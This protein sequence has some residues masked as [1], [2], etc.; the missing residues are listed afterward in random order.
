MSDSRGRISDALWRLFLN[1]MGGLGLLLAVIWLLH[2]S[3]ALLTPY[4]SWIAGA[5]ALGVFVRIARFER[6]R[7]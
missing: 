7:W 1:A 6:E 3:V 5:V 4:V 2:L